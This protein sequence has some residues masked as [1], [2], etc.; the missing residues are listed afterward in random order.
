MRS[1]G[2]A[3]V[4]GLLLILAAGL[5]FVPAV[6]PPAPVDAE[7]LQWPQWYAFVGGLFPVNIAHDLFHGFLGILGLVASRNFA[8]A[9]RYCRLVFWLFALLFVLGVI[10]ITNTLFGAVPIYGWDTLLHGLLAVIFAFGGYGRA[11]LKPTP[12]ADAF[13]P[14]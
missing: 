10:P 11:S 13:I 4:F 5:A 3:R 9:K 1:P 6:S 2:I 14:G 8:S 7:Y 12:P